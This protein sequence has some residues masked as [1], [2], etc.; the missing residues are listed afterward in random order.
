MAS[1]EILARIRS[2][3]EQNLFML[4]KLLSL[5]V[6]IAAYEGWEKDELNTLSYVLTACARSS[7]SSLLLIAYGQFWDAE[8]L[9]RSV[10]EGTLKFAYLLQSRDTFKQRYQ[11]YSHDLFQVALLKDHGKAEELLASVSN[12][13]D[14]EWRPIRDRLLGDQ[15]LQ[16][17]RAAYPS[18]GRR[19]L[20][21]RWGFARMMGT[22]SR[23]GE[24]RVEAV[25]ALAHGYA[26]SSHVHHV[27]YIGAIL[28][29]EHDSRPVERRDAVHLAHASRL[30]SDVMSFFLIRLMVGYRFVRHEAQQLRAASEEIQALKSTFGDVY[31]SWMHV[32]YAD[33]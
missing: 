22:L 29:F 28:P 17:L 8:I 33:R 6:P 15:E 13:D 23:P 31:E 1:E 24:G 4:R 18:A 5:A 20:E 9:V 32:E 25:N 10:A 12:P 14:E 27:D 11:E 16:E 21:A 30:I 7:E 2:S 26:I 19:D 3:A